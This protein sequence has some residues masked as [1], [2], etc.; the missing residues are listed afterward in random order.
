M[1]FST[2]P[3]KVTL[4]L[5]VMAWCP[6]SRFIRTRGGSVQVV[7]R[8]SKS[9]TL[10][11][12]LNGQLCSLDYIALLA[13]RFDNSGNFWMVN[14]QESPSGFG[15]GK[16]RCRPGEYVCCTAEGEGGTLQVPFL[17]LAA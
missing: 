9:I 12:A 14:L 16:R 13:C 2:V 8:Q 5:S 1:I 4:A 15:T 10:L 17:S 7:K 3:G 11:N 6:P